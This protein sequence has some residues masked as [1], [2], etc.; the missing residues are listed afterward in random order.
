MSAHILASE[1][2]ENIFVSI[3]KYGTPVHIFEGLRENLSVLYFKTDD[4]P[5]LWKP[6]A[7]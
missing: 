6:V 2:L 4:A 7:S 1:A 3:S 5:H